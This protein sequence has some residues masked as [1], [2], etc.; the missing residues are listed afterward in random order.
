MHRA[1]SAYDPDDNVNTW[2]IIETIVSMLQSVS[3]T[4]Y[5]RIDK[6]TA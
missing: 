4:W 2:C 1:M 5:E 6:I 3:R